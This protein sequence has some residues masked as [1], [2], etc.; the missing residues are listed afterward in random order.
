[1]FIFIFYHGH[2]SVKYSCNPLCNCSLRKSHTGSSIK[3]FHFFIFSNEMLQI[4]FSLLF[5]LFNF[6]MAL[7]LKYL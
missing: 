4:V 1:M 3:Y 7:S 5:F 6:F 2:V